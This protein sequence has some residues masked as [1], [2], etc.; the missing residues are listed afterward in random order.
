MFTEVGSSISVLIVGVA[1]IFANRIVEIFW[2]RIATY[3]EAKRIPGSLNQLREIT[4]AIAILRDRIK[5]CRTQVHYFHNGEYYFNGSP[6]L[7]MSCVAEST[8]QGIEKLIHKA[9]SIR[10][11]TI[12]EAIG[13]LSDPESGG[14]NKITIAELDKCSFKDGMDYIGVKEVYI[15]PIVKGEAIIGVLVMHYNEEGKGDD[16]LIE[17]SMNDINIVISHNL[18]KTIRKSSILAKIMR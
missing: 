4:S 8:N 2:K 7:K 9:Q 6:I 3:I 11:E 15:H 16:A 10:V 18:S 17:A 12:Q 13:F 1:F 5:C 14:M